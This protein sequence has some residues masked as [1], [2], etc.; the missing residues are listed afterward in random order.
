MFK[1]YCDLNTQKYHKITFCI[2][3]LLKQPNI[4]IPY[5]LWLI[6][7]WSQ[8]FEF[9]NGMMLSMLFFQSICGR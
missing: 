5:N 2:F 1:D 8:I 7:I 9:M 4:Y 6:N 3:L